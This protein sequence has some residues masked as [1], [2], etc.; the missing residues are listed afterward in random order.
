MRNLCVAL[1]LAGA[2]TA[3]VAHPG[4]GIGVDR[5]GTVYFVDTG[6]GVW[7]IG[8][9]GGLTRHPGPAF[10]WMAIDRAGRF[11]NVR[12][13]STRDAE[14]RAAGTDPTLLLS[15]D[16]PIVIGGDGGLYFA[17]FSDRLRIVRFMP[18]GARSVRAT[19]P[20]AMRW[21]NGIASGPHGALYYTEDNAVRKVDARGAV[22]TVAAN[23]TVPNCVR[24]PGADPPYLRGLSVDPTGNVFVAA[25][26]CGAVLKITP[27]GA[28]TVVLRTTAPWSPTDVATSPAGLHVLEYLHTVSV[29]ED[30]REWL[31][32]VRRVAPNGT[33]TTVAAITGR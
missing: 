32:R 11:A 6:S 22:S 17:E 10:H 29:P 12:L 28:V 13:P 24:I 33:V 31:P 20:G 23:V 14:I 16:F 3:A 15:S 18:D 27:R 25:S 7:M 2:V 5:R 21:I 30:R 9:G 19:L 1:A 4:S 8:A 26:G